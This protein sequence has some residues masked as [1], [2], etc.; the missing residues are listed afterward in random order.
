M[1]KC[2]VVHADLKPD[3][4]LVLHTPGTISL[5]CLQLIDFGK[6]VD[7][8]LTYDNKENIAKSEPVKPES[9]ELDPEDKDEDDL[10]EDE[11]EQIEIEKNEKEVEDLQT[12]LFTELGRAGQ[13]HLDLYGIAGCA[14]CLLFGK[15]IEVGAVKNRWVVKG[16][17]QRRWQTKL[18]LQFFDNFLNPKR[19]MK[20]LP[21]LMKWREKL[22][23]LF[24]QEEDLR[25]GL[26]KAQE[27]IETKLL[28]KMRRTL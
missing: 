3:N 13:Y 4:F 6:S 9:M 18:W 8:G 28:E 23:D 1:H 27:T 21:D 22:L 26:K 14:Y 7:L 10:T 11:K 24:N 17:F 16:N 15:Y 2:E 19:D 20:D 5:P 12:K 25:E